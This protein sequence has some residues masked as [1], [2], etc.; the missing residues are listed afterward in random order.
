MTDCCS[1]EIAGTAMPMARPRNA[2]CTDSRLTPARNVPSA[3][4]V[5]RTRLVAGV[6]SIC[7]TP[8]TSM[9]F[10]VTRTAIQCSAWVQIRRN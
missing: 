9:R 10:I 1:Q 6:G 2:I 5:R 7:C 3:R 4:S 8:D